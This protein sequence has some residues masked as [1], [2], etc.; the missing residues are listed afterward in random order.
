[1]TGMIRL[2]VQIYVSEH[3]KEVGD[4]VSIFVLVFMNNF[5]KS[6]ENKLSKRRRGRKESQARKTRREVR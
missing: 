2:T 3:I 6:A 4:T 5:H 1:M